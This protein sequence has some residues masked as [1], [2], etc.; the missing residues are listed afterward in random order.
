MTAHILH[1][2]PPPRRPSSA[3]PSSSSASSSP[4]DD[5]NDDDI[6]N[7]T[8]EKDIKSNAAEQQQPQPPP[9]PQ[10]QPQLADNATQSAAEEAGKPR[11]KKKKKKQQG[12]P[13]SADKGYSMLLSTMVDRRPV[14]VQREDGFDKR[15]LWRCGRCRVVVGY[16]LD[17]LH[18]VDA[19]GGAADGGGSRREG[20]ERGKIVYLLPGGLVGTE[21][22]VA[23]KTLS[24]QEVD[25]V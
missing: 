2:P 1:L 13:N 12:A 23:G 4:S 10:P 5:D 9:Q 7:T 8:N 14:L 15:W 18:F 20:Q 21:D 6:N 25:L 3:S 22:M 19:A 24:D 17:G 16:E 11:Q